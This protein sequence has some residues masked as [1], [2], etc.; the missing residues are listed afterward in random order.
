M[1]W[2]KNIF[3]Q[4]E[5]NNQAPSGRDRIQEI[6]NLKPKAND[7]AFDNPYTR[8][9]NFIDSKF[10]KGTAAKVATRYAGQQAGGAVNDIV[11][12]GKKKVNSNP[13]V[14]MNKTAK[15]VD[16]KFGYGTAE[17]LAENYALINGTQAEIDRDARNLEKDVHD[18]QNRMARNSQ[19]IYFVTGN[20][21]LMDKYNDL[22]AKRISDKAD[23]LEDKWEKRMDIL[24][25]IDIK[26][27]EE[28][29]EYVDKKKKKREQEE[30][31]K[32]KKEQDRVKQ[33]RSIFHTAVKDLVD[34]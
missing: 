24:D 28:Q 1:K 30:A 25:D 34:Y 10:G 20:K 19:R 6:A 18:T 26:R 7:N 17:R 2:G 29:D 14:Q 15:L 32:R 27:Q 16:D 31:R 33:R 22:E 3:E 23:R 8:A 12:A 5:S 13:I 11:E 21:D 4:E 9:S